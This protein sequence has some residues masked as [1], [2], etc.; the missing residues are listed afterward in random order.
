MSWRDPII[1][2]RQ[3]HIRAVVAEHASQWHLMAQHYLYCLERA[4]E[5]DDARAIRFF[6]AKL[7][8]AY[9]KMDMPHKATYYRN[10]C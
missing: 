9:A 3:A 10:L 6:A 1:E 7:S 2:V 8:V 4:T 5:A